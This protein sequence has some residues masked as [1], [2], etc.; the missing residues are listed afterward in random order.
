MIH[1][2]KETVDAL[3][4][5]YPDHEMRAV[6][7]E[8]MPFREQLKVIRETDLLIAVHGAGN[9]HVLFLPFDAKFIEFYPKGFS[10]RVRFQ[11]IANALGIYRRSIR[12]GIHRKVNSII[13]MTLAKDIPGLPDF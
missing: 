2:V 13:E 3:R 5:K 6:S 11:F 7:F 8:G 10:N 1:D 4:V 9:V 12:G